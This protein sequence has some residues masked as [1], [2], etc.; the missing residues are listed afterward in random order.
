MIGIIFAMGCRSPFGSALACQAKA[1]LHPLAFYTINVT[2]PHDLPDD[3]AKREKRGLEQRRVATLLIDDIQLDFQP[4][5]N[6]IEETVLTYF[7][8]LRK[9]KKLS[10]IRVRFDGH[11]YLL[12]D[13]FHR[14]EA[15]RRCGRRTV[16]AEIVPGTLAEMEA[17]FRD[18]LRRLNENLGH[19]AKGQVDKS[20]KQKWHKN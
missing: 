5:A 10:P 2:S 19:D 9:R 17:E 7:N 8:C 13:G 12:E 15:A 16:K 6:L 4:A 18:Y 1:N 11:N 3:G 14:V 20:S